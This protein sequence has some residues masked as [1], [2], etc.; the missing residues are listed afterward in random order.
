[1][2]LGSLNSAPLPYDMWMEIIRKLDTLNLATCRLVCKDWYRKVSVLDKDH[3]FTIEEQER[4]NFE[5]LCSNLNFCVGVKREVLYSVAYNSSLVHGYVV[6]ILHDKNGKVEALE[7]ILLNKFWFNENVSKDQQKIESLTQIHLIIDVSRN[8]EDKNPFFHRFGSPLSK[9]EK[10]IAT[11]LLNKL[12]EY[13]RIAHQ[14]SMQLGMTDKH[15]EPGRPWYTILSN[16]KDYPPAMI[17]K[18]NAL[19]KKR[20]EQNATTPQEYH[21]VLPGLMKLAKKII[22]H[23]N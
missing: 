18:A 6:T 4:K 7:N 23:R 16:P 9:G 5:Q 13:A 11:K 8:P 21:N 12:N 19:V 2:S 1:M 17:E 22:T 10:F 15:D 3:L 14:A 20:E